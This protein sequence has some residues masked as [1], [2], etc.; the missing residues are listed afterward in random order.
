M[1]IS[2]AMQTTTETTTVYQIID[3]LG[4]TIMTYDQVFILNAKLNSIERKSK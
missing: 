3:W 1:K 4:L 2:G